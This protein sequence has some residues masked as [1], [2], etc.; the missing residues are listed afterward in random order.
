MDVHFISVIIGN[1]P[2]MLHNKLNGIESFLFLSS[3]MRFLTVYEL[4]VW[5]MS[6]WSEQQHPISNSLWV[7]CLRARWYACGVYMKA[8]IAAIMRPTLLW[9]IHISLIMI[10]SV[11]NQCLFRNS[12]VKWFSICF[13]HLSWDVHSTGFPHLTF[14]YSVSFILFPFCLSTVIVILVLFVSLNISR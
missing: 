11:N 7:V 10:L 3:N 5:A 4:L 8:L 2:T 14:P 12:L 9:I 1:L 6:C 13:L